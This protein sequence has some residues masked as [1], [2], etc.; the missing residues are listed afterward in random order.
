MES[1]CEIAKASIES[2]ITTTT[3]NLPTEIYTQ[4]SDITGEPYPHVS[5]KMP[6][7][8]S[9]I[10]GEQQSPIPEQIPHSSVIPDNSVSG[11]T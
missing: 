7:A 6:P 3:T 4:I 1:E 5:E 10:T 11:K 8:S 9:G 2:I